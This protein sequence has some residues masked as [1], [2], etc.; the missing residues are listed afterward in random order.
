MIML[1]MQ[2]GTCSLLTNA[3]KGPSVMAVVSHDGGK[4]QHGH[5]R[6]PPLPSSAFQDFGKREYLK[7]LCENHALSAKLCLKLIGLYVRCN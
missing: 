3:K 5:L 2:F 7:C 4:S 1:A 6:T